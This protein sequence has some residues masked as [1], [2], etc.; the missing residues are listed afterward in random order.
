MLTAVLAVGVPAA[1]A[2]QPSAVRGAVRVAGTVRIV[3]LES[4]AGAVVSLTAPGLV[5]PPPSE[6]VTIDQ[7]GFRFV[8]RVM[9]IQTGTA[10]RF[11]NYD[12]EPHNVYSPEGRYNL[13]VWPTGDSRTHV[14]RKA[15]VYSQ[16]CSLHPDMLAYLVVVDTPYFAVSDDKGRFAIEDVPP[17]RYRA[18]VWHERK[19]GLERDLAVEPGEPLRLELVVER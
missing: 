12:P 14:F 17:G 1:L 15:G 3:G 8:P 4:S 18:V 7:K 2:A 9:A 16:R 5:L 6:P 19:N 10:V 11:L 13:G